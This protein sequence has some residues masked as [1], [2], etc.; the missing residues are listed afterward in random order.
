[1]PIIL[2]RLG[3]CP[4]PLRQLPMLIAGTGQR[5][6]LPLVARYADAWH[7]IFPEPGE[8]EPASPRCATGAQREPRPGGIEWSV[9]VEPDDLDRFLAEDAETCRDGLQP[10][11]RPASMVRLGRRRGWSWLSWRDGMNR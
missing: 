9:G 2:E 1:M 6:T 5:R 7:A 4:P 11:H 8:L 10:V 3:A